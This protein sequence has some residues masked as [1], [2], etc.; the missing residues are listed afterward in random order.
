LRSARYYPTV[1][2]PQPSCRAAFPELGIIS[3]RHHE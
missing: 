2:E 1:N 3:R